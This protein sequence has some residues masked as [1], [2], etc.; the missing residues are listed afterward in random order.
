MTNVKLIL[1]GTSVSHTV[2]FGELQIADFLIQ[3]KIRGLS[4]SDLASG[5]GVQKL[6]TDLK[7]DNWAYLLNNQV[8]EAVHAY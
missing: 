3:E 8:R 7:F 1:E 6:G 4:Q 5:N 2:I